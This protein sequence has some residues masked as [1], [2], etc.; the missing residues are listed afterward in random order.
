[1]RILLLG[2]LL[3]QAPRGLADYQRARAL[4]DP[5]ARIEALEKFLDE[6]GSG[7][8][9]NRAREDVLRAMVDAGEGDEAIETFV[10][11]SLAKATPFQLTEL[12]LRLA[13]VLL[14]LRRALP[15]AAEISSSGTSVRLRATHGRVLLARGDRAR[16]HPV[17]TGVVATNPELPGV[18]RALASIE[19][20][21]M[22]AR[23]YRALASLVDR[24]GGGETF[25]AALL[26]RVYAQRFA[27]AVTVVRWPDAKPGRRRVFVEFFTSAS[28][29]PCQ[30][31][32]LAFDALLRRFPES[33]LVAVAHH[34]DIPGPD[35]LTHAGADARRRRLGAE[36]V[37]MFFVDGQAISDGGTR[38]AARAIYETLEAAVAARLDGRAGQLKLDLRRRGTRLEAVVAGPGPIRLALIERKVTYSGANA[39]RFHWHVVREVFQGSIEAEPGRV[40]GIAAWVDGDAALEWERR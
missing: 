23:E 10:R 31:A 33:E 25:D 1:M 20:D 19:P 40:W 8:G 36:G 9:A 27:P 3:A 39:I 38:A 6:Y 15:V 22:L 12:P 34:V 2:L 24:D 28:C 18:A 5:R 37:P 16:A 11:H 7:G 4:T 30:G 32:E 14:E 26:D 29:L 13:D 35:P 17:L 21:A